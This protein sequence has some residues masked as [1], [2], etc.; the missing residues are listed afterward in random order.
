ME[1]GSQ[2]VQHSKNGIRKDILNIRDNL[3]IEARER[4]SDQIRE[5]VIC[6]TSYR[7]AQIILAYASYLSEVDTMMLIGQALADGKYVFAP[8]VAGE[9][10]EFW[11]ITSTDDLHAGYRGIPEPVQGISF[12]EWLAG[13]MGRAKRQM[14]ID[15][16][17]EQGV[18]KNKNKIMIMMWMPGA[19]FDRERHRIGYGKGFYDRYL[20]KLSDGTRE[21]LLQPGGFQ[22]ITAALAYSCQV[23]RQIPYEPHDI[24]P[25]MVVT[26]KEIFW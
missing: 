18:F 24:K 17:I 26:E 23:V 4:Y 7:E 13:R 11:Q 15:R 16:K 22:L 9:D 5:R 2:E 21:E 20:S 8:K 3:S 19:V 25:D 12:P 10:M 14:N 1:R 6:H